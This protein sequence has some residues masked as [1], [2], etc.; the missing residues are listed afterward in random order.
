MEDP[1]L[2]SRPLWW[3]AIYFEAPIVRTH[4]L[5]HSKNTPQL[6]DEIDTLVASVYEEKGKPKNLEARLDR[7]LQD[8]LGKEYAHIG[9]A[10]QAIIGLPDDTSWKSGVRFTLYDA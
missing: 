5:P 8:A 4:S 3:C 6:P 1:L 9:Q 2:R 7:A 10:H